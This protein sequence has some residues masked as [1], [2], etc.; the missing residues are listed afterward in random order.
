MEKM[1]T[2]TCN[3]GTKSEEP[4]KRHKTVVLA[5]KNEQG[6]TKQGQRAEGALVL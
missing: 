4:G 5:G 3:T 2:I 6:I 1:L